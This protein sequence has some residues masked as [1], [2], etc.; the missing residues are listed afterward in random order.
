M[1][2]IAIQDMYLAQEYKSYDKGLVAIVIA[3]DG[4]L[5]ASNAGWT[6]SQAKLIASPVLGPT[7]LRVWSV[8]WMS[9]SGRPVLPK[10]RDNEV[11]ED[12]TYIRRY[13]AEGDKYDEVSISPEQMQ[14]MLE[15]AGDGAAVFEWRLGSYYESPDEPFWFSE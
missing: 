2:K 14:A 5:T 6:C 1:A 3:K 4:T 10:H 15:V 7:G 12:V 11:A 13:R 8:G 9:A